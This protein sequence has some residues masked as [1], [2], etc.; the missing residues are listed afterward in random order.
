MKTLRHGIALLLAVVMTLS[1]LS[2]VA[3]AEETSSAK[4]PEPEKTLVRRPDAEPTQ[5]SDPTPE[6][7][8]GLRGGNLL[9]IPRFLNGKQPADDELVT[10][11]VLLEGEALANTTEP[12]RAAQ[13]RLTVQHNN[14][15]GSLQ[16]TGVSYTERF[17]YTTLLNGMALSVRYGDLEK[18]SKLE[19]VESVHVANHYDLPE[20]EIKMDSSNEMTGAA[21]MQKN[22]YLGSGTVIAVLDTGITPQHEAF[23]VYEGMLE[24]AAL[25]ET[26]AQAQIET[27]GHGKYLSEKIPFSFDY[28][29]Q[30]DDATDDRSG[31]GTHVSAIAAGYAATEDGGLKF[32]GA[33]PD[34]QIL[35]M[36]IFSSES[37]G[38]DS[39]IYFAALEDAYKLG[40]N[41]VNM[42]IGA[43]NGFTFDSDLEDE[44][45]GNIFQ[46]LKDHGVAV[47]VAA[48]NEGSQA[49]YSLNK[50]G[51][52]YVT[53]DYADY[54]TVGSPSTYAASLSV[55]SAE[56][57][58][59]PVFQIVAG[60]REIS[61]LDST[62]NDFYTALHGMDSVEFAVIPGYGTEEDFAG[63][64]VRGRIALVSR[65][66]ITF[67]EK[68]TNAY[69]SGAIAL[70]VYNNE[71]GVIG[72]ALD[73][74]NI[75][76]VMV[77]QEDGA[78]LAS[79]AQTVQAPELEPGERVDF[80][81]TDYFSSFYRNLMVFK[82]YQKAIA[83]AVEDGKLV[84][85]SVEI[86]QRLFEDY[87]EGLIAFPAI[88]ADPAKLAW[89][90]TW[91]DDDLPCLQTEDGSFLTVTTDGSLALSEEPVTSWYYDDQY[92]E[93]GD[94]YGTFVYLYDET[95][96]TPSLFL[97]Y[98]DEGV[99]LAPMDEAEQDRYLI[100]FFR[101]SSD[102][103][104]APPVDTE[105]GS[106]RL[107]EEPTIVE[108]DEAW[109]MSSFSSWGPTP[110]LQF[111]P[112]ITG[113]GG[114]VYA[115][116][117]GTVD[118]YELMSGTSMATPDLA[119]CLA[120]MLQYLNENYPE[121]EQQ[122]RAELAIAM[123]QS[124]AKILTDADDV[125]Y[126]VRKQGAGLVDLTA[127]TTA[128][129]YITE[130]Q[131]TP[132]AS[133]DGVYTLSFQVKSL[134]E[135]VR[136]RI[137]TQAMTD[138]LV[139]FDT[140]WYNAIEAEPLTAADFSVTT[141]A[142][143]DL[144]TVPAGQVVTV[145]VTLT[146]SERAKLRY[147]E[148]FP[149]GNYID[150]FVVLTEVD[151][152]PTGSFRFD[153]VADESAY[154]FKPVYWA[155]EREPQV[156]AGTDE[157]HFS[158]DA[159][160]TR[161]QVATFLYAAAGKPSFE[162]PQ[163]SFNDVSESD[164]YYKPVM[165]ALANGI[166]AGM[167][168]GSFGANAVCTREQIVTFL[169][170]AA[171][172]P[173]FEQPDATF[174]DATE[175]DWYYTP[176][177]WA[178]AN[179]ITAGI[180]DGLFGTGATCT[181]AQIV[182]FLYAYLG[183]SD[184][185][186]PVKDAASI[187]ASFLGFYGDWNKAPIAEQTDWRDAIDF[188]HEAN[189]T[190]DDF[191]ELMDAEVNVGVNTVIACNY[192][193]LEAFG[194]LVG[195]YAGDNFL[196]VTDY[197]EEHIALSADG[198]LDC[199]YIEPYLLRNARRV[200]MTV[201]DEKS[202]ELVYVENE[203]YIP[204]SF[205]YAEAGQWVSNA[206]MLYMPIDEDYN[207]L[208]DGSKLRIEIYAELDNGEDALGAIAPENLSEQAADY[209]I[210]SFPV[211]LDYQAPTL[212]EVSYDPAAK[213]L[214][215]KASDEQYLMGLRLV[216]YADD[217]DE[218][219]DPVVERMED[220][221]YSDAEE[222]LSHTAVFNDVE[223][224]EQYLLCL[225][226]YALN[227]TDLV[228]IP[229]EGE[230]VEV[231]LHLVDYSRTV[232]GY[233]EYL[234]AKGSQFTLPEAMMNGDGF[235]F[236]FAGWLTQ[237]IEGSLLEEELGTMEILPAGERYTVTEPMT[238]YAAY[239]MPVS[240]PYRTLQKL[241]EMAWPARWDNTYALGGYDLENPE[242]KLFMNG[243]LQAVER[244]ITLD[245]EDGGELLN[246]ATDEILFDV[247][248]HEIPWI[249][250]WMQEVWSFRNRETGAYVGCEDGVLVM[251]EELD[252]SCLWN[253][254]FYDG[255]DFARIFTLDDSGLMLYDPSLGG[256]VL[257]DRMTYDG[258]PT[259]T[260]WA[261]KP[262]TSTYFTEIPDDY[263]M[264]Y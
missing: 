11:I 254:N 26:A 28:A 96:E 180:G 126:S 31:H 256:F 236:E 44:L 231:N 60:D 151:T 153:D 246:N 252:D 109:L 34:A 141:N 94:Y 3:L 167:G 227:E 142:E 172:K 239:Q 90:M 18:L 201:T 203:E 125:A 42:S 100:T 179:G 235:D 114:N 215:V 249:D 183:S 61:Y 38:T 208:P 39:S 32:C 83:S 113:I 127:A 150:G 119:G 166:T 253:I 175:D 229:G 43:Q 186:E 232:D 46:T 76:A 41:V 47:V 156:T 111:K 5:E 67:A 122:Q 260:F 9:V 27:L 92:D 79:L 57:A 230:F 216:K 262:Y 241:E 84:A 143:N 104:P 62:G 199:L 95:E 14:F 74:R 93:N 210:M 173:A 8:P 15:R 171:G 101:E 107:A 64:M 86:E 152:L 110:D 37:D 1:C 108:S 24:Q 135:A 91:N 161:A 182:T 7:T 71:D 36:K 206:A 49:D 162:L 169:Y 213:Q 123:L 190:G 56:N 63:Q 124:G 52:G 251:K 214:T 146:L 226:D 12:T 200:V 19:G 128:K 40:A 255:D 185:L 55:A 105:I 250:D 178:L 158:P 204:K 184:G 148:R 220:V 25:T 138:K 50:A 98:T 66:D 209:R 99:V 248:T 155:Y 258:D 157:T 149:N 188:I 145:N 198:L 193:I 170:A 264:P 247:E 59:Y 133:A 212:D 174:T 75:P 257:V 103:P 51:F 195:S 121:V 147:A 160:C 70:V 187:H 228:L 54:G 16:K 189:E 196:G 181:R 205:F 144:V 2:G 197:K 115:A 191:T 207:M 218:Y 81:E 88:V 245:E 244:E 116:S 23:G 192:V 221:L 130:P 69:K 20:V 117:F 72:M 118:G 164:W 139:Q 48:G 237:P 176:V 202:G 240:D 13:T 45:Y 22:G 222:G 129:A 4:L 131:L 10:A 159:G 82:A 177:M 120:A 87:F 217:V 65:G 225:V 132:G 163:T 30:D 106:L 77:S 33:A 58:E 80:L 238:F 233:T 242:Q 73:D 154:Y 137:D 17:D 89:S 85:R 140:G 194:S 53:A 261:P 211:S 263:V 168:D 97:K 259:F 68:A 112:Q 6:L 219:G 21:V 243:S 35:A 134:G 165:W 102:E 223:D 136:Y 224:G 78:Y 234:V 29:D